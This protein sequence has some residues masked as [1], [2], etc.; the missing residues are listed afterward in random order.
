MMKKLSLYIFLLLSLFI[1]QHSFAKEMATWGPTG[2]DCKNLIPFLD[3]EEGKLLVESEIR[4]FLNGLNLQLA[5]IDEDARLKIVNHNSTDFALAYLINYCD[6][7]PSGAAL[8]GIL[9]YYESLPSFK[10]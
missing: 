2:S 4:G 10:D 1:N 6:K 8:M 3:S 9:D 5:L 7:N